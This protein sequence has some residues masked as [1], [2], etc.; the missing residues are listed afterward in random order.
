MSACERFF[1]GLWPRMP[2][3]DLFLNRQC[4]VYLLPHAFQ[5]KQECPD[6]CSVTETKYP[7]NYTLA[8]EHEPA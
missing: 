2:S 8:E 1:E 3:S 6:T 5:R 7:K 4:A